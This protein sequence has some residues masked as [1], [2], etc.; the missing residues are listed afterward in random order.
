MPGPERATTLLLVR[1]GR[2]DWNRTGRW[3]GQA[4]VPLDRLGVRQAHGLADLV[5]RLRPDAVV[6]SPL[7][8]ARSTATILT[9]VLDRRVTLGSDERLKEV[10]VGDWE[11]LLDAE[12]SDRDPGFLARRGE[13]RRFSD[14][15]E[16]PSEC[17]ARV[18]AALR[19]IA[20]AQAGRT[21]VVVSHAY[22]IRA[23][24]G[25]LLG[26]D[27]RT[28]E[29]LAGLFNCAYAELRAWPDDVWRLVAWNV[30]H[31]GVPCQ[32]DGEVLVV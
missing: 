5:G 10:H 11:G 17:G 28:T 16:R 1:H 20:A 13:D 30:E 12:V 18:A 2:T 24:V 3:H 27:L 25:A 23:A 7:R 21:V 15:G 31:P 14:T 19:D 29:S 6:T 32:R 9:G 26:W 22:A 8:R 4:D